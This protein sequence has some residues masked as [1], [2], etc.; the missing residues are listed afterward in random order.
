MLS[1]NKI[2]YLASLSEKKARLEINAFLVEGEKM[3]FELL[4]S[5]FV[6]TTLLY[7]KKYELAVAHASENIEKITLLE[8]EAAKISSMKTPQGIFAV[9]RI[10]DNFYSPEPIYAGEFILALQDIQDPGN[11]GTIVRTAD[12]FGIR[13]ILCSKSTADIL[14][15]KVLQ[16]TMGAVFRVKISYTDLQQ[17]IMAIKHQHP[18]I[19]IYAAVLEGEN[20]Y[21]A[22]TGKKGI[23]MMGNESK[24]LSKELLD[25]ATQ[26][27]TIPRFGNSPSAGES[28]N[29]SIA[30]AIILSEMQ[31]KI[32]K[33][34]DSG[35]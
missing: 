33:K 20:L 25:L 19:P 11:L 21:N 30:T 4:D 8:T 26:K 32:M 24:G 17:T 28:L 12:W 16:S 6:V 5:D 1:K 29:V 14:N 35:F 22:T 7:T 34:P 3:V 27:L 13:Q 2:K 9:A 23:L 31:R 15:P 18:E 10:P